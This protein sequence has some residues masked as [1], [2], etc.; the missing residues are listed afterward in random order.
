MAAGRDPAQELV[1]EGIAVGGH[2]V[3]RG[4]GQISSLE[5][6]D[7]ASYMTIYMVRSVA[8]TWSIWRMPRP[9]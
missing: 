7:V 6:P 1:I 5:L 8:W 4:H 3:G 9:I 2:A